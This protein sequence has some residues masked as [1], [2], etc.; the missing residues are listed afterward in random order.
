MC[1][2]SFKDSGALCKLLPLQWRITDLSLWVSWPRT[3]TR[4]GQTSRVISF[5]LALHS[6]PWPAGKSPL[7]PGLAF[8]LLCIYL[9]IR[10]TLYHSITFS[11]MGLQGRQYLW[12]NPWSLTA[13]S[14]TRQDEVVCLPAV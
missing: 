4:R 13:P 1:Y 14:D 6:S 12:E 11:G 10:Q 3:L 8:Q 7:V 2:T 9:T 5:L